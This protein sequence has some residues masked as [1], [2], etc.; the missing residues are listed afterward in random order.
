MV[1]EHT[2]FPHHGYTCL[3]QRHCPNWPNS[4][5]DQT[6]RVFVDGFHIGTADLESDALRY[7]WFAADRL[8]VAGGRL[9]RLTL[10][11]GSAA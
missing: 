8:A 2:R 1:I 4:L 7:A 11:A 3:I 5:T 10:P 6:Y 9:L